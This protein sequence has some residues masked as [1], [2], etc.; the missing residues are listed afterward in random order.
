MTALR[1]D[2]VTG[3]RRTVAPIPRQLH[4]GSESIDS[5]PPA[6]LSTPTVSALRLHLY[7]EGPMVCLV[8]NGIDLG[9]G[10]VEMPV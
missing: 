5:E 3:S 2:A 10:A 6:E 7:D 4:S 1:I 8:E 9:W